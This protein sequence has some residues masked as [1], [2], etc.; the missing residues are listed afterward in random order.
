MRLHRFLARFLRDRSAASAAE[1]ALVLPPFLLFLLGTFDVGRFIWFVNE[2]EKAAQIGARWAVA[3]NF[4]CDGVE[5]WSFAVQQSPPIL[6]GDTVPQS[7]FP[8]VAFAGG[9]ATACTCAPGGTCSFPLTADTAAFSTLVGRMQEIQPRLSADDVSVDYAWSGL[10]YSGDPNG[11]DVAPIVTV[12]IDNLDF[13][14]LFLAGLISLGIPGA[15]YSLTME[16]GDGT[17]AN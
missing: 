1:F 4:I 8:G 6:Q 17:Y 11:P 13:R 14:P 16:D 15:Q 7:V 12:R 5:N 9:S 10:G 3:T 2:N